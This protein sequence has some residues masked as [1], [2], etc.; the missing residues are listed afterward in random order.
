MND[1]RPI[2]R[3]ELDNVLRSDIRSLNDREAAAFDQGRVEPSYAI[4]RRT[5]EA[6]DE[7]VFIVWRYEDWV[8]YFDDVE[9]GF[10]LSPIG[11][12]SRI[13]KHRCD[14]SDLQ[15]QIYDAIR[16]LLTD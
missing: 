14:Q 13:L 6:G 10:Q 9:W 16:M 5:E 8:I 11:A 3:G 12:E 7:L 2:T 15:G 1:W 4:L